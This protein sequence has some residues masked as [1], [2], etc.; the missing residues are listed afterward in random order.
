MV[1]EHIESSFASATDELNRETTMYDR[2]VGALTS[3]NG[4]GHAVFDNGSSASADFSAADHLLDVAFA[5]ALTTYN[6]QSER[7]LVTDAHVQWLTMFDKLRTLVADPAL[8]DAFATD[9]GPLRA[10]AHL[11]LGKTTS[12]HIFLEI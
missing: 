4:T 1:V 3:E 5:D 8:A 11:L 2:L 7:A 6:A 9:P 12:I 10:A